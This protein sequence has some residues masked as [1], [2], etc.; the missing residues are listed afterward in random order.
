MQS[1]HLRSGVEVP[2]GREAEAPLP[3]ELGYTYRRKAIAPKPVPDARDDQVLR[4]GSEGTTL[5][6]PALE[7]RVWRIDVPTGGRSGP[8]RSLRRFPSC[9]ETSRRRE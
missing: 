6:L 1:G 3:P 2:R 7:L 4:P 9:D 5:K 8:R